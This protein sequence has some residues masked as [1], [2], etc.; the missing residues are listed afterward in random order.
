MTEFT[1]ERMVGQTTALYG[2]LTT[3]ASHPVVA[4]LAVGNS[5]VRA[6][7]HE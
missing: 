2:S 4:K 7:H 5:G 1:I 6:P 3:T